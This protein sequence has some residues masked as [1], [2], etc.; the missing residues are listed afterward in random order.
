MRIVFMGTPDFAVPSLQV[1]AEEHELLAV[2]TQP[3]RKRDRGQKVQFS[4]VKQQALAYGVPIFQPEKINSAKF[5]GTLTELSPEAIVVV[6]FGQKIPRK[7]LQLPPYGCIN[8]HASLLPQYRGAAPIQYAIMNGDS[9][10]GVTTMYLSEEWDAGDI[11]LQSEETILPTDTGAT[12]HDRLASKGAQLLSETLRQIA[13]GTAPRIPQDHTAATYAYKLTKE[14]GNINWHL[15]AVRIAN[16]VRG[17]NPW[18]GAY[19]YYGDEM[20]KVW[21]ATAAGNDSNPPGL[22]LDVSPKG[23]AVGT[24]NG[25][26]LLHQLQ[27][28]CSRVMNAYDLANGLRLKA[29]Q[30]FHSENDCDNA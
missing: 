22:V 26:V 17:L 7:I 21:H 1:V 5:I 24:P 6:A 28:Q 23:I 14:D 29:G 30:F 10:T 15:P 2:V 9:I 4:P 13:A 25:V 19:T 16:L 20:I 12:L 27:R 3:D 8:V 11:I 18:P